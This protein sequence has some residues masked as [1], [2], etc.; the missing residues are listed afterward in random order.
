MKPC[1]EQGVR[2]S[3]SE[4][5]LWVFYRFSILRAKFKVRKTN[6]LFTL[7]THYEF[8]IHGSSAITKAFE[9]AFLLLLEKVLIK[10]LQYPW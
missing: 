3:R 7:V 8:V 9:K 5:R 6:T 10:K 4:G 2:L 1:H